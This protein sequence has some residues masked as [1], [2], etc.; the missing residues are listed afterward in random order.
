MYPWAEPKI[1]T[2]QLRAKMNSYEVPGSEEGKGQN[3]T[4]SFP[5]HLKVRVSVY[6]HFRAYRAL[7]ISEVE[8][9]KKQ[10]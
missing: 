1:F 3:D 10:N 8:T 9:L 5:E 4:R 2:P 6:S 7:Q